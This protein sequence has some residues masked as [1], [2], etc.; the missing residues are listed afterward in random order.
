MDLFA[1]ILD[2]I[3]PLTIFAKH[4][5]LGVSQGKCASD[6]NKQKF[7]ALSFTS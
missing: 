3:Q 4:S 1:N 6:K 5:V 2:C 7:G